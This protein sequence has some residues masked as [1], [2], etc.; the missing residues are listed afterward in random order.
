[1]ADPWI[2]LVQAS[3]RNEINKLSDAEVLKECSHMNKNVL[4]DEYVP[5]LREWLIGERVAQIF[6]EDFA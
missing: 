5:S 3:A 4:R 1:M 6:E 2:K